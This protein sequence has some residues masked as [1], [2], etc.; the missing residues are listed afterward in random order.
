MDFIKNLPLF[1]IVAC[2]FSGV[3]STVLKKK[4]ARALSLMLLF[5][6]TVMSSLVL[7]YTIGTG[8]SFVYMMGHFPAPFGNEIRAG[9]LEGILASFFSLIMF[10][11]MLTGGRHLEEDIVPTKINL[12]YSLINLLL[13][14]MLAIIYTNDIFTGYVFVEINTIA[15][16]GLIMIKG[17]GKSIF[18]TTKYMVMSLVGSGLFMIGIVLLY[19]ITG[20]LLMS[21]IKESVETLVADGKYTEPL[22]AI[23]ALMTVGLAIKSALYPFHAWLPEAHGSATAPSSAILSS[24]VPK[25]YIILLMKIF[26]R[27][28]GWDVILS[29]GIA[30]VTYVFGAVGIVMGSLHAVSERNAKKMVAFSSIAQIGYIYMGMGLGNDGGL[31]A[32]VY[33]ILM[34]AGAKSMLFI[35]LGG[36]SAVSGHHVMLDKLKGSGYRNR[37]AGVVFT[38]GGL[39]ITGIPIFSGF[40]SKI[41]F[42]TAATELGEIKMVAT[43]VVLAISTLLNAIYFFRAIITIYTPVDE[44]V[45]KDSFKPGFSYIVGM[46]CFIVVGFFIGSAFSDTLKDLIYKGLNM[47]V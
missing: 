10:L 17:E 14:S 4:A 37:V 40:V 46:A 42:A 41:N 15:V 33:H 8:E 45:E 5:S 26:L 38:I 25:A 19:D 35:S 31:V 27:V 3:L 12:Y 36:L 34:H 18:A 24:L 13:S 32:S 21:N 16:A 28:I 30:N 47:F 29:S 2:L 9:I 39:T 22:T 7:M 11:C 6:V 20:H 44:N 1:C 23:V 43:L